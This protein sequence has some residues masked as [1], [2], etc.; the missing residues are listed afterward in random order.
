MTMK[1]LTTLTLLTALAVTLVPA[2]AQVF[3]APFGQESNPDKIIPDGDLTGITDTIT[4]PNPGNAFS[5]GFFMQVKLNIEGYVLGSGDSAIPFSP[6]NGD[7]YATLTHNGAK[8]ILLNRSGVETVGDIGYQDAGMH[9]ILQNNVA[10]NNASAAPDI[11]VYRS[12]IDPGGLALGTAVAPL[13]FSADGRN[14]DPNQVTTAATRDSGLSVFDG[15]DITGNWD[16]YIADAVPGNGGKLT[17]W[18]LN[19]IAVPEP[20][21]YALIA[22]FGLIGFALYR[23]YAV[24]AA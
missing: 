16:L 11:H 9:V 7:F 8:A 24:K 1:K 20:Q 10:P 4:M 14:V 21:Q 23:R 3:T 19:F 5:L 22:S 12:T 17:N 15:K 6:N 18:G 2:S 13:T